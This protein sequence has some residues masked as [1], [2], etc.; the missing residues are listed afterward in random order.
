MHTRVPSIYFEALPEEEVRH[1][2]SINRELYA[3]SIYIV[4][5]ESSLALFEELTQRL[6][7]V[8]SVTPPDDETRLRDINRLHH[9]RKVAAQDC[10]MTIFHFGSART[11]IHISLG[12]TKIARDMMDGTLLKTASKTFSSY[13]PDYQPIRNGIA[14]AE[15]KH[16]TDSDMVKGVSIGDSI[17]NAINQPSGLSYSWGI[18]GLSSTEGSL[19]GGSLRDSVLSI[20][21]N[22]KMH[23]LG[24]SKDTLD[25]LREVK[26]L[27]YNAFFSIEEKSRN[28]R[29]A[30]YAAKSG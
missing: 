3:L 2:H 13:F 24:I 10:A 6:Y 4:E 29:N 22:N 8:Y 21:N 19:P 23:S 12:E 25:R 17:S 26:E 30:M 27:Y 1:C 15:E 9:W 7:N 28:I 14:H 11:G 20:S 16:M 18:I 5:F